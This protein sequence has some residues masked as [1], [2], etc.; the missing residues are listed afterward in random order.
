MTRTEAYNLLLAHATVHPDENHPLHSSGF[1]AMLRPYKRL[2]ESNFH[3]VMQA[4]RAVAPDLQNGPSID[5]NL[6]TALW[7]I[8]HY[9][10]AWALEPEGML[11]KNQLIT[12]TD[13]ERLADWLNIISDTVSNLLEGADETVAFEAYAFHLVDLQEPP[14]DLT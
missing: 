14:S 10:R 4:L 8:C 13:Q 6:M 12:V 7:D 3:E 1:L 5:R 9:A 11:R 2:L